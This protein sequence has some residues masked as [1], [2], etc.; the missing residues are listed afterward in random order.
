MDNVAYPTRLELELPDRYDRWQIAL[1]VLIACGLG[2][3][4][5]QIGGMF[6]VLYFVLPGVAAVL[7][8]QRTGRGY[9]ERDAG[10]LTAALEWLLGLYAYL[11]FVT[12]RVPLDRATRPVHLHITPQGEPTLSDALLRMLTS[13]P[14]AIL[15][16][17]LSIVSCVASLIMAVVVLFGAHVPGSLRDFQLGLVS[18]TARALAYHSSLV[19]EYPPFRLGLRDGQPPQAGPASSSSP[20]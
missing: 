19:D 13:L 1:R 3:L 4:H 15:L 14:H 5:Q 2:A 6:G 17:L 20:A 10:W 7:I 11:L 8:T 12:D 16:G 9:L 18:W